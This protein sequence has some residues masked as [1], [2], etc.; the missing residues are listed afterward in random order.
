M[1]EDA[2]THRIEPAP[3]TILDAAEAFERG[4]GEPVTAARD[5]HRM[6][7]RLWRGWVQIVASRCVGG[8][9]LYE[10]VTHV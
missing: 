1:N 9:R 2:F 8:A 3:P 6:V 5:G 7:A 10:E 4:E